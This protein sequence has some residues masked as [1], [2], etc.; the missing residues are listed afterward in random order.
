[1]ADARPHLVAVPDR[2]GEG[3]P[4]QAAQGS[5]RRH[6][7]RGRLLVLALVLC[8]LGWALSARRG[9][10][11]ERQLELRSQALA[12]ARAELSRARS[13]LAEARARSVD[14]HHRAGALV[15]GLEQLEALLEGPEAPAAPAAPERAPS[16]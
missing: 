1:M 7:L 3:L 5:E 9:Q 13:R 6:R 15:A 11:L 4:P 16:R 8:V 2:G 10:R 14:L 12:S